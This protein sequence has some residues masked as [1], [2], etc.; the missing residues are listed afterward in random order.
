MIAPAKTSDTNCL[1]TSF[2]YVKCTEN[3]GTL[4]TNELPIEQNFTKLTIG[5]HIAS[6]TAALWITLATNVEATKDS[7]GVMSLTTVS[8]VLT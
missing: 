8:M 1:E 2:S 3:R 4:I 6:H 7:S 5:E